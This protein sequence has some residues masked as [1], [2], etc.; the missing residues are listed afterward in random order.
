MRN[1][2]FISHAN[3]E[4]NDQ[5]RWLGLQLMTLGYEVW[6]DVF[7]LKG[8]EKFWAEIES[9]I[10]NSTCKFLYILT[11][12]SNQRNGCLNELSV[13]EAVEKQIGDNRFILA[14]HFDTELK[15]DNVNINLKRKIDLN[16]KADWQQGLKDLLKIFSEEPKVPIKETPDFAFIQNYWATIYLNDR[17]TIER[18]ETYSSNW[19]PFISF[20]ENLYFH[21]FKGMI[22]KGFDWKKMPFPTLGYKRLT[23]TFGSCY[24]F[25]EQLP[26]TEQYNLANS[27][28]YN[29]AKILNENLEDDFISNKTLRNF[30]NN[31]ISVGFINTMKQ[32]DL[33]LY[34]MSN[35]T[36]FCFPKDVNDERKFG[37]GQLVGKRKE[38]QWHYAFSSFPDLVHNV[39]VLRSH[40]LLS[41]NG[42]LV[43]S[44]RIQQ[45]GRRKQG[46]NWWNKHWKHKLLSSVSNIVDEDGVLRIEV[47][48]NDYVLVSGEPLTFKSNISYIDP[49][50]AKE[51]LDDHPDEEDEIDDEKP[52]GND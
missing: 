18:E 50:E 40:I 26:M 25:I 22:P 30:I 3:T 14:L 24:D 36:S 16:F 42:E 20:P 23:V 21:N 39:L 29:V 28:K 5:A 11:E 7:N 9:E 1:K 12:N 37:H 47:G 6:C 43:T 33:M 48:A 52:K 15:H 34:E 4:D 17:K 32:K 41:E 31:L 19:F 2:I 46:A 35:K 51:A 8:G 44:K 49:D 45:S 10:R 38:R 13:A 27:T